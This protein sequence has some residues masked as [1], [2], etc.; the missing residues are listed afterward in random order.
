M[1]MIV[2]VFISHRDGQDPLPKHGLLLMGDQC[3]IARIGN[4]GIKTCR[5]S[6]CDRPPAAERSRIGGDG[7]PGKIREHM[8]A[9]E[10]GK[11]IGVSYTLSCDGLASVRVRLSGNSR[12]Y[13][14]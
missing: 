8:S 10:A 4:D 9:P 2:A 13:R 14:M 7:S 5:Q 3:L 12:T 1:L 6:S 11:W